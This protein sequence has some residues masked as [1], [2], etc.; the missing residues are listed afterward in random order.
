MCC[1]Q[2]GSNLSREKHLVWSTIQYGSRT[3]FSVISAKVTN[4]LTAA[5]RLVGVAAMV[6]AS[7]ST[8]ASMINLRR[9]VTL[10]TIC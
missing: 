9:V 5:F 10:L 6:N 3:D 8:A 2:V 4:A 1:G 7:M